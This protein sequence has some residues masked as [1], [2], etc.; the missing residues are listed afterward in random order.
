MK[1]KPAISAVWERFVALLEADSPQMLEQIRAPTSAEAIA[2]AEQCLQIVFPEELRQLYLLVDGF[3]EG[4]YL[5]RDDLRILPLSEM[6]QASLALVGVPILMD[7]LALQ[8]TVP[9]KVIHVI[10]AQAEEDNPDIE[11]VSLRLRSKIKPP[12]VE[13]WFREGGIHKWEDIVETG[14]TLTEWFEECLEYYG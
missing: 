3:A 7:S 14:D 5:L 11:Q 13:I 12:S 8:V 1:Q 10:F 4:A 6:V 9:K 2:E